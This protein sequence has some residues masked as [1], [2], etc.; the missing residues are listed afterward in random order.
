MCIPRETPWLGFR[1]FQ[2]RL[3]RK[4]R[5]G[6]KSGKYKDLV[7]TSVPHVIVPPEEYGC[8]KD[9]ARTAF[10]SWLGVEDRRRQHHTIETSSL[11]N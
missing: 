10:S 5:F 11:E 7:R 1:S 9:L 6:L 2:A 8:I 3:R 4:S